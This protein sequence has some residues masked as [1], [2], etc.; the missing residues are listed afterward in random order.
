LL[1]PLSILLILARRVAGLIG[2]DR[3][4]LPAVGVPWREL[5]AVFLALKAP[6]HWGTLLCSVD[7]PRLVYSFGP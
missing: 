4:L 3:W 1:L 2:L 5:A 7:N 6:P